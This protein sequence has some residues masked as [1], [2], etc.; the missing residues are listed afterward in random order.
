M[1]IEAETCFRLGFFPKITGIGD[2]SE[3]FLRDFGLERR[4]PVV[5]EEAGEAGP[6]VVAVR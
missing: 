1:T 6:E 2:T 4:A 5:D 3:L